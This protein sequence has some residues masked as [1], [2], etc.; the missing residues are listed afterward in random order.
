MKVKKFFANFIVLLIFSAVVFFIG[1]IQFYVRPGTCAIMKSKTGGLYHSAVVPGVFTWRWERLLPTNVSLEIFDL[2]VYKATQ[3]VSGELP[4]ASFYS[5]RFSD[6]KVDFSYDV[7]ISVSMSLSPEGIYKLVS[8]N[9]ITSNNDLKGFY[10]AKAKLVASLVAEYL[11]SSSL[12]VKPSALSQKEIQEVIEKKASEFDGI[13]I[14]SVELLDSKIPD[15][16]LYNLAKA[17]YASYL[18]L[19]NSKMAQKAESQAEFFVEQDRTLAQLE[20][21]GS[22]LQKFP[23]LEEMFKTGDAAQI[24]NAVKSMR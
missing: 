6:K 15:V 11:V 14:S 5:S 16:E 4:S 19:L 20:K 3:S 21:L 17:N 23:Q 10:D 1:W 22:M 7:E 24:I 9:K 8:E 2:S 13:F 18:E 12:L